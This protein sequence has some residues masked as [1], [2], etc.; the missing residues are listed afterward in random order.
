MREKLVQESREFIERVVYID[1]GGSEAAPHRA[2]HRGRSGAGAYY[3]LP[4]SGSPGFGLVQRPRGK[5][6]GLLALGALLADRAQSSNSSPTKRGILVRRKLLCLESP[7][8]PPVVPELP[9]P[10]SGWRTTRQRFEQSHALGVCG[11]CHRYFDPLGFTLES[12]DEAGRYRASEN[13]EPIDASGFALG[14]DGSTLFSVTGGQEELASILAA[15]PE[16]AGCIADTMVKYLLAQAGDCLGDGS[17]NDFV[18]GKLGFLDLAAGIAAA[19]HF[20]D[21]QN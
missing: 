6:V 19:P 7:P 9:P 12:F 15:R 3:G 1:K 14:A 10:G 20:T 11:A 13:G 4:A 5:G 17:R 16:V 21:R 8:Q 18:A 2:L